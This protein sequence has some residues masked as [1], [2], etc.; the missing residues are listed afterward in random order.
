MKFPKLV[1]PA[2]CKTDIDVTIYGEGITEEGAPIEY[3][4][5][6]LKCNYQDGAKKV[7]TDEKQIVEITGKA[8]FDG[9]ICPDAAI[10]SSGQIEIFGVKRDIVQ[11]TKARNPD[12]S[13]NYTVLELK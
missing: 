1:P 6:K 12:G 2:F 11:G 8:Y 7:L 9:D 10:I 13:V 4:L 3:P 5:G